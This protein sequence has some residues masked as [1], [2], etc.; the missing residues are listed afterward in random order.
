MYKLRK[1]SILFL[2]FLLSISVSGQKLINSPFSRFN[3]GL[4]EPAGSF[5]STGMGGVGIAIRDNSAI[6]YLNPASYS[7]I[8]TTSFIFDFGLDYGTTTLRD[9]T[10]DYFSDDMN[11]DHLMFGFPLA[12]GIGLSAGIIPFSSG[13]YNIH[14]EITEQ[15]PAYDEQ[16][17]EYVSIHEGEGGLVKLFFGTGVKITKYFSAGVNLIVLYGN[18]N[19]TNQII[20][21]DYYNVFHNNSSENIRLTGVNLEYGAQF[22]LPLGNDFFV[23]TGVSFTPGRKYR[24]DYENLVYLFSAYGSYDTLAYISDAGKAFL[25][26]TLRAGISFGKRDKLTAGFDYIETSWSGSSIPG[27]GT[28]FADSKLYNIGLEYIPEK[29]SIYGFLNRVEYRIGAHIEDNYMIINGTQLKEIGASLGFG[30]PL[31]R[32][33]SKINVYFDYTKRNGPDDSAIPVE[34]LYTI[35]VSLNL[36]DGLWF[37]KPKYN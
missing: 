1:P 25:P 19:R 36:Y 26:H 15:D 9:G 14:E 13:Y 27:T 22:M 33:R 35:G 29:Y 24:S 5:R 32:T 31:R 21:N 4:L 16:T 11:F 18:L 20:F 23:N 30:L 17:G 3:L 37:L 10:S 7:A 2:I 34:N 12:K 28:F 6:Y 8:D